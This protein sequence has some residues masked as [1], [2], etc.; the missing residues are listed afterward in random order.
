MERPQYWGRILEN[1]VYGWFT[2]DKFPIPKGEVNFRKKKKK[3]KKKKKLHPEF[4][5]KVKKY[6]VTLM[7]FLVDVVPG[8]LVRFPT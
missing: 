3:K 8:F 5:Q 7:F 1:G 6:D 4:Q 2:K